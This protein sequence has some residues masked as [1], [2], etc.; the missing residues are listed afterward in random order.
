M[1]RNIVQPETS[2]VTPR[3]SFF[4]AQP[5]PS[6]TVW[7][8]W[9]CMCSFSFHL[10]GHIE[11]KVF[12]LVSNKC[13]QHSN[14]HVKSQ[15]LDPA[16]KTK[17]NLL[18]FS[19]WFL[20]GFNGLDSWIIPPFHLQ[21]ILPNKNN[22]NTSSSKGYLRARAD[23]KISPNSGCRG[24]WMDVIHDHG[25]DPWDLF[26]LSMAAVRWIARSLG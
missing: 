16:S 21:Q 3:F 10:Q 26:W 7:N 25:D 15:W 14:L 4:G 17:K 2:T 24:H 5:E 9:V 19:D 22:R 18:E 23:A 11:C 8:V 6:V 13:K 12:F 20:T 1:T